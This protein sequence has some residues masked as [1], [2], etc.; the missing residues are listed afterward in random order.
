M[1]IKLSFTRLE[2]FHENGGNSS[3][4]P[5][6]TKAPSEPFT[7]QSD[8]ALAQ[9]MRKLKSQGMTEAIEKKLLRLK[10]IIIRLNITKAVYVSQ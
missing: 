10:D 4:S 6:A 8:E 1:L 9:M 2:T 3:T 5:T 7:N